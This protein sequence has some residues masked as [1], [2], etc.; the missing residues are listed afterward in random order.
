VSGRHEIDVYA[1]NRFERLIHDTS[2][3]P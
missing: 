1:D 3:C 2:R